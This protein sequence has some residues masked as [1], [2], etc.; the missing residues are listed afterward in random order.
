MHVIIIIMLSIQNANLSASHLLSSFL[1]VVV[2]VVKHGL[3]LRGL[4]DSGTIRSL[5]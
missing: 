5:P 2:G 3:L 1:C 4:M